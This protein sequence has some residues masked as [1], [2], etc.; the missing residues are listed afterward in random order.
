MVTGNVAALELVEK[1]MSCAGIMPFK[2]VMN[3]IGVKKCIANGY[4]T[5]M[6]NPSAN[7]TVSAY[8]PSAMKRSQLFIS[9]MS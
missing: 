6:T 1:A 4:T 5:K 7:K 2:K 3:F 8:T 9:T